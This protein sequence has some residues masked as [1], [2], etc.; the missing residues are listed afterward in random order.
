[1]EKNKVNKTS[2][3]NQF[4]INSMVVNFV[5]FTEMKILTSI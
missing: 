4:F 1:M 2:M 3:L 5:K